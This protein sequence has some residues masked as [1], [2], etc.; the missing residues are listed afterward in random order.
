MN[1]IAVEP[2]Q[3]TTTGRTDYAGRGRVEVRFGGFGGQ[4]I[5]LAGYILG[6]AATVHSGRNAVMSQSYGPQSRG[7]ACQTEV[8]ISDSEIAYPRVTN[9]DVVVAMSQE[10]YRKY[11]LGRPDNALLIVDEDLVTLDHDAERGRPVRTAPATRL[12][13]GLGK[14]IIAN[15]VM[16]GFLTGATDLL[17]V[18]AVREAVAASVPNAFQ[19]LNVSAFDA[20]FQHA[21]EVRP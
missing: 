9:T 6:R 15:I 8:V 17:D 4:G 1:K 10:A 18:D 5:I 19:E 3:S 14:R 21:K 11:G 16:L 7:G 13:E 12:A 2:T 20:G